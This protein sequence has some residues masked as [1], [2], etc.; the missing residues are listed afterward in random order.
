MLTDRTI[1]FPRPGPPQSSTG[2]HRD[3]I[4]VTRAY[5]K[6]NWAHQRAC[7]H[8]HGQSRCDAPLRWSRTTRLSEERATKV[9]DHRAEMRDEACGGRAVDHAMVIGERQ[10]QYQPRHK[11]AIAIARFMRQL[12]NAE[13]RDFG[14]IDYWCEGSPADTAQTRDREASALYVGGLELAFARRRGQLAGLPRD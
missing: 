4:S 6:K 7:A 13:D 1:N 3:P 12:R 2:S 8:R 5:G 11:T 9:V 10:R 14:R